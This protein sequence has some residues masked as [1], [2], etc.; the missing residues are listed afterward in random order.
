MRTFQ[1]QRTLVVSGLAHVVLLAAAAQAQSAVSTFE[2]DAPGGA[3]SVAGLNQPSALSVPAG[4]GIIVI[5][6]QLGIEG[7]SAYVFDDDG[8]HVDMHWLFT[9]TFSGVV[10]TEATLSL[11]DTMAGYCF[12][13]ASGLSAVARVR[14]DFLNNIQVG[15][16]VL[17]EYTPGE[18][19]RV[20]LDLDMDSNTIAAT[21]DIEMDGFA[22][23]S[24]VS[25]IPFINPGIGMVDRVLASLNQSGLLVPDAGI[26]YDDVYRGPVSSGTPY[27]DPAVDNS[28]GNPGVLHAI[29]SRYAGVN[30]LQLEALDLP[31]DRFGYFLVS[32]SQ[33][34]I[35]NPGGSA[36]NLCLGGTIGRFASLIQSS[37]PN[38]RIAIQ[39]DLTDV[40]QLGA[41]LGGETYNFQAWFRDEGSSNFT[42]AVEIVFL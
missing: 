38:G 11:S 32:A 15:A 36:G 2:F 30:F 42:N 21:I 29:G 10:R 31:A 6:D 33:G 5:E 3:P 35:A 37:G 24:T 17:G 23:N 4:G 22:N 34:F 25:G 39:P 41:L 28:T 18:P 19:F 7:H 12:Q 14:V 40:P 8:E 20:R 13:V 27:C 26:A 16:F 9:P 1:L